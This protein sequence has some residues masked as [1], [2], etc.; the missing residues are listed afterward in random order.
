[1]K[2]YGT[3]AN[4]LDVIVSDFSLPVWR[5]DLKL[6]A[7]VTDRKYVRYLLIAVSSG[8]VCL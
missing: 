7:I 1:M 2:Y 8:L 5:D 4:Y 6:D 3:E